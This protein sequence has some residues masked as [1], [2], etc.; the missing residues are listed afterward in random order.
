MDGNDVLLCLEAKGIRGAVDGSALHAATG[1][2]HC[3]AVRIMITALARPRQL[4][5]WRAPELS[6]PNH[7]SVLQHPALL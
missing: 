2:P 7:Q 5:Y 1:H 4:N 6:S 3:E